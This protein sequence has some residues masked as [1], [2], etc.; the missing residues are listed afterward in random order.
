MANTDKLMKD[1]VHKTNSNNQGIYYLYY[2]FVLF[3]YIMNLEIA[4]SAWMI[5]E[6]LPFNQ[7]QVNK[8]QNLD[9]HSGPDHILNWNNFLSTTD[10]KRVAVLCYNYFVMEEFFYPIKISL[11][12]LTAVE[13]YKTKFIA[14]F[15][16][17]FLMNNFVQIS[18]LP[19][20]SLIILKGLASMFRVLISL[21]SRYI[22][23][24]VYIYIYIK[25][26]LVHS[27]IIY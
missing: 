26:Y 16:F 10:P 3:I 17:E 21:I 12:A 9:I 19:N 13:E 25:I 11:G 22:Y 2:N 8:L 14:K 6:K 23:I 24:Y 4:N 5:L 20:L 27:F 18:Q 1:L 7:Q 15:G